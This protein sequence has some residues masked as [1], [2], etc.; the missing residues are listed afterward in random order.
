[1]K[2]ISK[3]DV[4]HRRAPDMLGFIFRGIFLIGIVAW[5]STNV[6]KMIDGYFKDQF[7][8]Y[9]E[10]EYRRNP[11]MKSD[12]AG[13]A[14][15]ANPAVSTARTLPTEA[16]LETILEACE[17]D[18]CPIEDAGNDTESPRANDEQT[19][20][21]ATGD[22]SGSG[23][24]AS[25]NEAERRS[26]DK[27]AFLETAEPGLESRKPNNDTHDESSGRESIDHGRESAG[28][29]KPEEKK[30]AGKSDEVSTDHPFVSTSTE[31]PRKSGKLLRRFLTTTEAPKR[32]KRRRVKTLLLTDEDFA[33]ARKNQVPDDDFWEF[34]EDGEKEPVE[35]ILVSQLPF[36]PRVE[37]GELERVTADEYCPLTLEEEDSCDQTYTWP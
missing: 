20:S 9:L 6:W 36:K 3:L 14:D 8:S 26:T 33:S 23:G 31:N 12:M 4:K 24:G 7:R 27:N 34:E 17:L 11:R 32:P 15:K 21:R 13:L 2:A 10:E 30:Q 29:E 18:V 25:E 1:M 35:G 22:C 19:G 37:I 5:Y 16:P 28:Q